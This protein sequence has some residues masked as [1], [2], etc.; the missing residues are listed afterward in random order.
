MSIVSKHAA[1]WHRRESSVILATPLSW[2][3]SMAII[4]GLWIGARLS[5][6]ERACVQSFLNHGHEFHLYVYDSV[7]NAPPHC[8]LMDA[9]NVVPA[10]KIFA[11]GEGVAKGSLA[12][13][14][15]LFRFKLLYEVGGWWMDLDMYCL[16]SSLPINDIVI[17]RQDAS[18]I[19]DA[20]LYFPAQ[21]PLM[22]QAYE[23]AD[24]RG[25]NAAWTEIGPRL[26][27][28]LFAD[29]SLAKYVY[30]ETVFYPVHHSQFWNLYDPRRTLSAEECIAGSIGLHF[31]NEMIRRA[32]IDKN[33]LPP[34]NS[35]MR[36]LYE[37]TLTD[38]L[39]D[40]THEYEL[41]D[42]CPINSLALTLVER[43]IT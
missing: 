37:Q 8:R 29:Q 2:E 39:G 11:H 15:N 24:A 23:E 18:L 27:S 28:R 16:Q 36:K 25:S 10:S 19:N 14:S 12:T 6:L 9:A 33:V 34:K 40:F 7:A 43:D 4:N 21:H 5:A 35:L 1:N 20:V 32:K 13:F 42:N 26:I 3:F 38:S 17:G 41:S 22:L 31:W 30:P